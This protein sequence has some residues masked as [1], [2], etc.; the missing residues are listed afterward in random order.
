M[1][2]RKKKHLELRLERA[3]A[4]IA[5]TPES[6]RGHWLSLC[7]DAREVW[8]ELGC[9][10]GRFAVEMAQENPGVLFIAM[11]KDASAAL[12]GIERTVALGIRNLFFIIGDA[13]HLPDWFAPH[14]VS[15]LYLNFSDPW[16]RGN[17]YKRRLT[18]RGFLAQYMQVVRPG[19]S[20]CFK[21][22]NREL[23]LF[24]LTEAIACGLKIIDVTHNLHVTSIPN[25]MTEY[26]M[27]FAELGLPIH[28]M[29]AVFPDEPPRN[30]QEILGEKPLSAKTRVNPGSLEYVGGDV[31]RTEG[32]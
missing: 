16:T 30:L 28:R 31:R 29:E 22:D 18:Y 13:S 27:K 12:T 20:L 25:V 3:A 2:M 7:P 1:R 5:D 21:T 11:E 24:S 23:F 26:E 10:K 8:L 19:A 17:R 6:L 15:R 9:G 4:V 32:I 14:E